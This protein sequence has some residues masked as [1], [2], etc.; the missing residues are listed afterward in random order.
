MSLDKEDDD[1]EIYSFSSS[2]NNIAIGDTAVVK[3][4]TEIFSNINIE[5]NAVNVIDSHRTIIG[6]MND[7]G[8]DGDDIANDGVYSLTT[9]LSSIYE[10]TEN[11]YITVGNVVS[12]ACSID[13]YAPL[14]DEDF[15][16]M[17][18]VEERVK[19]LCST[20]EFLSGTT[21]QKSELVSGLLSELSN[22]GLIKSDSIYY[23]EEGKM[24]IFQYPCRVLSGIQLENTLYDVDTIGGNT[25]TEHRLL[26]FLIWFWIQ[27]QQRRQIVIIHMRL[28]E[29]WLPRYD[30]IAAVRLTG[31]IIGLLLTFSLTDTAGTLLTIHLFT[32]NAVWALT[33]TAD[34]SV[35]IM[36][37][38]KLLQTMV[39]R[40]LWVITTA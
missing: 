7:N 8:I 30:V 22:E 10:K 15:S 40:S 2:H 21:S 11:Y 14:T 27:K 37:W 34:L 24:Y 28:S 38:H 32:Y 23:D 19:S 4:T 20:E 17:R 29:V 9:E 26:K 33:V 5:E 39:Q 3:F 35:R 31:I 16:N 25:T 13:Y 18:T 12:K 36:L 6:T 1:I